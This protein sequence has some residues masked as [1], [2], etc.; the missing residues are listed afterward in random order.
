MSIENII[1]QIGKITGIFYPITSTVKTLVDGHNSLISMKQ[2]YD[3]NLKRKILDNNLLDD[4][5]KAILI[6]NISKSTIEFV[7]KARIL[8]VATDNIDHQISVENI[9]EDWLLYFFDQ[10]K[11]ISDKKIQEVWGKLLVL[12]LE[13]KINN[14]KKIINVLSLLGED[15]IKIFCVLCAMTFDN[16]LRP[17][18]QYPFVYID[19]YPSYYNNYGIRRYNL[20]QLDN[21][22]I[23][24]YD[25]HKN[26]VL[27]LTIPKLKYNDYMVELEYDGRV[28]N[29]NIRFTEI[30]SMLY[31]ITKVDKLDDFIENCKFVWNKKGIKY[32]IKRMDN[33]F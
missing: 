7:N 25:I 32:N 16:L 18:K 21:L 29:G 14:N 23:I 5:E 6:S 4:F 12:Y 33:E 13:G 30:G 27:P 22:G 11:N 19:N 15:D 10:A 8:S 31:K 3:Q 26:F 1:N 20:K 28:V 2:E 24:E 9:N 17:E